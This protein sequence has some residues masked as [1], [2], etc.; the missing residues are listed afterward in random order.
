MKKSLT[1]TKRRKPDELWWQVVEPHGSVTLMRGIY[2][3]AGWV[4]TLDDPQRF[5]A[6]ND[7]GSVRVEFDTQEEAKDFLML[8]C[9]AE[10]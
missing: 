2:S 3:V 9:A 4:L 6:R 1:L 10:R 5:V 7:T 8:L